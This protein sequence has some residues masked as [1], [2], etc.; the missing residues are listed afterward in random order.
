M[1]IAGPCLINDN[2]QEIDN[3][4][5]TAEELRKIDP[6][7][8]FRAKLWG[9]GLTPEIYFPGIGEKG[10]DVLREIKSLVGLQVGT[11]V[12]CESRLNKLADM[13]F[14]WTAAR[15]MQSYG[16]LEAVGKASATFKQ[17]LV[18]RHYAATTKET[19]GI[20][21]ICEKRYGFKPVI[22]ERGV[23]TTDIEG[24]EKWIPDFRFMAATLRERP[25]IDLMFDPSHASGNKLNILPFV[26]AA[27]AIGVKHYMIEVY[28]DASLT[29]SDEAQAFD[30][31]EFKQ[32]YEIIKI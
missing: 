10:L 18:K 6:A 4:Y 7:I 12:Q 26:I 31:E 1:I 19:W 27:N 25:D 3:A 16:F 2:P 14:I 9:G 17:V 24:W 21:D 30:I 23:V 5:K 32:I 11:E 13:D 29:Q 20:H 15:A 28:A 22:I 8:M